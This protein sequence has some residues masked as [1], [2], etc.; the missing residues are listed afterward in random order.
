MG[1]ELVHSWEDN[2]GMDIGG[3]ICR[4]NL[5]CSGWGPIASFCEHG[6]ES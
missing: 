4:L 3:R 1:I 2:V 5:N 6:N